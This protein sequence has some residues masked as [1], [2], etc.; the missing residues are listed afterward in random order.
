MAE[1]EASP[2]VIV[3]VDGE[4]TVVKT[5]HHAMPGWSAAR[6]EFGKLRHSEAG[7]KVLT[8]WKRMPRGDAVG[9]WNM[10]VELRGVVW[11]DSDHAGRRGRQFPGAA[12]QRRLQDVHQ[13]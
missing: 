8:V 1:V 9:W 11:C 5:H 4:G 7:K 3:E 6:T 13:T 12:G 2:F 10:S